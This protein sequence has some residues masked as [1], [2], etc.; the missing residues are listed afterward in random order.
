VN[1]NVRWQPR[2]G[3]R[4]DAQLNYGHSTFFREQPQFDFQTAPQSGLSVDYQNNGGNQPVITP[5]ENLDDPG[6]GWRWYRV[7]VSNVRRTTTTKGA[8]LDVTIG[9]DI[10]FRTGAAYDEAK[11]TIRA[12]DNSAAFQTSV[13]GAICDGLSGSVPNS[14]VAQFLQPM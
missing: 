3:L 7:N 1:P 2:E 8:H 9:D 13:C 4:V 11:R 12:F 10:N 14:Q 6:L 5:S